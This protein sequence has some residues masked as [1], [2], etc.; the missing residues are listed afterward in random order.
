MRLSVYITNLSYFNIFLREIDVITRVENMKQF[1]FISV[2]L[3]C[4]LTMMGILTFSS[5]DNNE[6]SISDGETFISGLYAIDSSEL[7]EWDNGFILCDENITEKSV[8]ALFKQ[9]DSEKVIYLNYLENDITNGVTIYVKD[10][11]SIGDIIYEDILY[12]VE[13]TDNRLTLFPHKEGE[14]PIVISRTSPR[15]KMTHSRSGNAWWSAGELFTNI[16]DV[17]QNGE[18]LC[19]AD[20]ANLIIALSTDQ[21]ISMLKLGA[22]GNV[23][24]WIAIELAN[25]GVFAVVKEMYYHGSKP[26]LAE[27][28]YG[29]KILVSI[30]PNNINDTDSPILLGISILENPRVV[31]GVI[32][33]PTYTNYDKRTSFIKVQSGKDKYEFVYDF[34]E[35]GNFEMTPF[36]IPQEIVQNF[37]TEFVREWF[38]QYGN[39]QRYSY[40]AIKISKI[41]KELCGKISDDEVV[42]RLNVDIYMEDY[43]VLSDIG[44]KIVDKESYREVENVFKH[45]WTENNEIN[46]KIEGK[47]PFKY[48]DE[49]GK[50]L[51]YISPYGKSGEKFVYGELCEYIISLSD[52]LCPDDNHPHMIDLGLPSGV[53]WACCNVGATSPEEYGDY[54]AWGETT[55]QSEYTY[56]N[57]KTNGKNIGDI[58]GNPEYDAATANWGGSWRM[59]TR[60]DMHELMVNCTWTLTTQNGVKGFKVTGSNSNSIFL[61]AAGAS[62]GSSLYDAGNFGTYWSSTPYESDTYFAYFLSFCHPICAWQYRCCGFSVR[63]VSQ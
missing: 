28:R 50:T 36:L 17:F 9:V 20:Y 18:K 35:I 62:D 46:I 5:C 2:L 43:S 24:T 51:L 53:K 26:I 14:T 7:N 32:H 34:P 30:S 10:D 23:L 48:F 11:N 37:Q 41:K 33:T 60:A 55:P 38:V 61:P 54:F 47:I 4:L 27:E 44:L 63:P 19:N 15:N 13:Y 29:N 57:C 59:P 45:I 39:V 42:F 22:K 8:Y 12:S 3:M 52:G 21:L 58:S 25:R 6:E 40:P 16:A 31:G 56:G 49:S 1:K